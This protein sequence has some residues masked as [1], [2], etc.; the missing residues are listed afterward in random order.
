MHKFMMD[1]RGSREGHFKKGNYVGES[2]RVLN[3]SHNGKFGVHSIVIIK[4]FPSL[5]LEKV[6]LS[7]NGLDDIIKELAQ[8]SCKN[9]GI[10]FIMQFRIRHFVHE[11]V[12]ELL[13]SRKMLLQLKQL[14]KLEKN[15]LVVASSLFS[16]SMKKGL[17]NR[18]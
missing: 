8:E 9:Q 18:L 2:Q 12:I 7:R 1:K 15:R 3:P 6:L 17:N 13:P 4:S 14:V 16:I 5:T 11:I 10:F